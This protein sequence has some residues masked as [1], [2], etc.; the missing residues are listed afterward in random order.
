[1]LTSHSQQPTQRNY[2]EL[3]EYLK[4][5]VEEPRASEWQITAQRV[6]DEMK[7]D[8]KDVHV[9][10]NTFMGELLSS[11]FLPAEFD[12][13]DINFVRAYDPFPEDGTKIVL[14]GAKLGEG[15]SFDV[16]VF[17]E[18]PAKRYFQEEF[19]LSVWYF[20]PETPLPDREMSRRQKMIRAIITWLSQWD[21]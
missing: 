17:V 4:S 1:M 7:E 20:R 11:K 15:R 13:M 14:A 5:N 8:L 16:Q 21:Y 12:G 6:L 18:L 3:I 9:P 19:R 2:D 10:T